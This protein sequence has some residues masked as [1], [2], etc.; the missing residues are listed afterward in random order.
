MISSYSLEALGQGKVTSYEHQQEFVEASRRTI[1]RHEL[2]KIATVRHAPLADVDI[3]SDDWRWYD[4]KTMTDLQ[5]IDL[6]IVD[7]PPEVEG[8]L[9][10]YPALPALFDHLSDGAIILVDDVMR[11]AET[12]MVNRWL[13]EFDLQVIE[14]I[15]N[16]KGA[17]VLQ[18]IATTPD[19][20]A[21]EITDDDITP[22]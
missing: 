7:G 21:S 13:D 1:T 2:E 17:V 19:E 18:K 3:D 9:S 20:S 8:K 5:D 22:E 15:P 16:E 11:Q 10:R 14:V 6:L 4:L 12:T